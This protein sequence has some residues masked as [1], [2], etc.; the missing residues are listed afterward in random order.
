VWKNPEHV[1]KS[2]PQA[3]IL[4]SGRVVFNIKMNDFRLIAAVQYQNGVLMINFFGSH[5]AAVADN[6]RCILTRQVSIDVKSHVR[7]N[8]EILLVPGIHPLQPGN[9]QCCD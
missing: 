3:S 2:H 5:G 8:R 6:Q 9:S 7:L 4:K 1:K